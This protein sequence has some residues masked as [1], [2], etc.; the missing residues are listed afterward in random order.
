MSEKELYDLLSTILVGTSPI[1]VFY[2]HFESTPTMPNCAPPFILYRVDSVNC[3]KAN[4][5]VHYQDNNYIVDLITDVKDSTLEA[6]IEQLFNDNYIPY[7][8][9]F[10]F[11]SNERIYQARYFI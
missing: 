2:D 1:N 11:I 4:D 3:F 6:Q 5:K 8:K 7:D 10:D 9:E